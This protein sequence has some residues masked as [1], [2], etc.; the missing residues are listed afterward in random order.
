MLDTSFARSG[1][2]FKRIRLKTKWAVEIARQKQFGTRPICPTK[3]PDPVSNTLNSRVLPER[4]AAAKAKTMFKEISLRDQIMNNAVRTENTSQNRRGSGRGAKQQKN[5]ASMDTEALNGSNNS[6]TKRGSKNSRPRRKKGKKKTIKLNRKEKALIKKFAIKPSIVCLPRLED[7]S[8]PVETTSNYCNSDVNA[9]S[10]G[11]N[12]RKTKKPERI[13][14]IGDS[15]RDPIV[16]SDEDSDVEFI[17]SSV[18][19]EG[20]SNSPIVLN[21]DSEDDE[22]ND[23]VD[24]ND[25]NNNIDPHDADVEDDSFDD[26]NNDDDSFDENSDIFSDIDDEDDNMPNFSK[27]QNS[28]KTYGAIRKSYLI[29]PPTFQPNKFK[30]APPRYS[31]PLSYRSGSIFGF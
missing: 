8:K 21:D 19:F 11:T 2:I 12:K 6:G 30:V 7:I 23:E 22:D 31:V 18:P 26:L 28:P 9:E 15:G 24:N 5:S 27:F 10:K 4:R 14:V 29:A 3:K 25:L 1:W 13:V 20:T 16:V 17:E